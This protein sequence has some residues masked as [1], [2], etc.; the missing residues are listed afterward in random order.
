VFF[1]R[2]NFS[3]VRHAVIADCQ[4]LGVNVGFGAK[5]SGINFL[6]EFA[7]MGI[8]FEEFTYADT[9]RPN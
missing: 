6:K 2:H 8:V 9:Q 4:K 7:Q 3:P 5:C 1:L